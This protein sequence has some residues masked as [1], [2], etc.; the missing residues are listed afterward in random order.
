MELRRFTQAAYASHARFL[1]LGSLAVML[2][3]GAG[4]SLYWTWMA[5][6][7]ALG[8]EEWTRVQR[9]RGYDV[10]YQGP[11]IGGFPTR[12]RV[13]LIEPRVRTPQGWHWS[14][15]AIA[16]ESMLWAPWRLRI[17]VPLRQRF[18]GFWSGRRHAISLAAEAAEGVLELGR[19]GGIARAAIE[20]ER[21]LLE[22]EAG[23]TLRAA[24]VDL[25][26]RQAPPSRDGRR[27]GRGD[28]ITV[29]TGAAREIVWS[30]DLQSPL[31]ETIG[32]VALDAALVGR[33][34]TGDP[35][36]ALVQW[37]DSGGRLEIGKLSLLWGPLDLE[38]DGT[39]ALDAAMRPQGAF[40][41]RIRGLP[42]TIDALAARGLIKRN[43][44]FAVKLALLALAR[45]PDQSGK[46]RIQVPI[47]LQ[48][49]LV[50]LGP[51]A[52]FSVGPVL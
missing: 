49:G 22:A 16:G 14:G 35:A 7:I 33:I 31:G 30:G 45:V 44:A 17:D 52:L 47:T 15:D 4:L 26:V 21:L 32:L 5:E 3:A 34:P 25:A 12:F 8:V 23:W 9:T 36:Q 46:P 6:R 37:R 1:I 27:E 50:Y 11:T 24:E 18:G 29:L 41:A 20:A 19:D 48:D 42:E 40:T 28:P 38:A 43:L 39:A 10:A 2:L 51:V 13:D